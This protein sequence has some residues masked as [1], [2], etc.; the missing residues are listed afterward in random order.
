MCNYSYTERIIIKNQFTLKRG[1]EL[2]LFYPELQHCHVSILRLLEHQ[3]VSRAWLPEK[4][5]TQ[6]VLALHGDKARS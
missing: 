5:M 3:N 2:L 1:R 4:P 6:H